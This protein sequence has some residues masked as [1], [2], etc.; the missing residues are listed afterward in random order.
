[1][2]DRQRKGSM[3]LLC[4]YA[5]LMLWLLFHREPGEGA[6]YWELVRSRLN[7]RPFVTIVRFVRLM[8]SEKEHLV[9]LGVVNLVGNVVMF[10]PMGLLL[11]GAFPG[12]AKLWQAALVSGGVICAV[13]ILQALLL[14]GS[15]DVDDLILNLVG[16]VIGYGLYRFANPKR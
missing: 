13:E 6:L 7:L 8:S 15:C 11:P 9:R 12:L 4:L 5:G 1:M 14:V 2:A 10:I 16:V 3:V